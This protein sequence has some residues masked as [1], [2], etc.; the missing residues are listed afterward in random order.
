[1]RRRGR[2]RAL[3][4]TLPGSAGGYDVLEAVGHLHLR[5]LGALEGARLLLIVFGQG[6]ERFGDRRRGRPLGSLPGQ[7]FL[8]AL[9]TSPE[10]RRRRGCHI[11]SR[12]L[13]CAVEVGRR[14]GG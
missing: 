4:L 1:G 10:V 7:E 9:A 2:D 5:L 12:L 13:R 8:G 6:G 14:R 11:G 3:G